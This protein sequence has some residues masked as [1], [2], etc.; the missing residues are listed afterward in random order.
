M[1]ASRDPR[2]SPPPRSELHG[3]WVVERFV[4]DGV[5]HPPLLTDDVRWRKLIVSEYGLQIRFTTDRRA[6]YRMAKVDESARTVRLGARLLAYQLDGD[7]LVS[8]DD[9]LR[10]VLVREPEPLLKTRGF[11]WIQEFPFNR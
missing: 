11:H 6:F 9:T 5:E 7:R 1:F 4:L 10:V 3:V 2:N 8:S